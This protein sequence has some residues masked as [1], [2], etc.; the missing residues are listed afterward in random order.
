MKIA[1][2]TGGS[3]GL[4]KSTALALAS[5][6][7]DVILT[8]IKNKTEADKVVAEIGKL[9]RK[10]VALQL[11]VGVTKSF[12]DFAGQVKNTLK[13]SFGADKFD[14]LI[15]NAG[16]GIYAPFMETTEEQFDELVNVHFKGM[17]FLTQKLVPLMKDGGHVVNLSSGLS[18][19]SLPGY[20]AYGSMKGAIDTMTRY[21][22]RELGPRKI[23]VNAVAPGAIETDFGGG[24]VRDT[25]E[26]NK[27]IASQT[28]L[29]RVGVADDIGPMIA[30]LVTEDNRWV[31]GQRIEVSGG[32]NI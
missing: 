11:D 31:T 20:A 30:S 26:L 1:I 22:A 9:G 14:I 28:P 2:V 21:M 16:Q 32:I 8:Y 27:M 17:Y 24:V 3:R 12:S 10:A 6:G 15:N 25:P 18:R 5:R 13:S 23:T 7:T 19:F 4:G 29:G